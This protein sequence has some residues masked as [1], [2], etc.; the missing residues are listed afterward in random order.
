[1]DPDSIWQFVLLMAL[2]MLSALYSSSE[3]SLMALSKIRIINLVEEK[4]KGAKLLQKI[5]ENP[6]KLLGTIL[7][8]NNI[9]NIAAS[10]IATSLA[11]HYYGDKGVTISTVVMTILVLIFGEIT[12]KTFASQNSEK[13]AL[14]VSKTINISMYLLSPITKSIN[15][16]TDF[17][18]RLL[19]AN[20]DENRTL[21]TEKELKTMINVSHEE[22]ILEVE[23]HQMIQN[24]FDFSDVHIKDVMIPRTEVCFIS[25]SSTYNEVLELF[26]R[27]Q[28]S[29]L[30]VYEGNSD[31]IIGI[32]NIKDL[33][34][35]D[36]PS[37]FLVSDSMKTPH[38]TYEFKLARDLFEEMRSKKSRMAI[39]LDEYGGTSGIVTIE[40][41]VE[42]VFGDIEDE[43]DDDNEEILAVKENEY[44]VYGTVRIDMIN[45]F[46]GI[47]I[48]TD[49]FD[50]VG[51]FIVGELGYLPHVGYIL[52]LGELQFEILQLKKNRIEKLKL[53][54]LGNNKSW[55]RNEEAV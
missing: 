43:Y 35:V 49:K 26:K 40:D 4:V 50:T 2:L 9:V 28:F 55:E 8:G 14:R 27:E 3:T 45:E 46:I 20:P 30:P 37:S 41:L 10:S 52:E 36:D 18:I 54:L 25:H 16:L 44:I 19:G 7:V 39:V 6:N 23:E 11:I 22:G 24:V 31:N 15:F 1:M 48:D 21:I 29:R 53:S 38:F 42:E 5:T 47:S 33:L 13:V 51:G 32:L 34:Y 12:P 17:L